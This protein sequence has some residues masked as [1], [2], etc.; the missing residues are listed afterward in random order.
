MSQRQV[1]A[2][3]VG[4]EW[5]TRKSVTKV[6]KKKKKKREKL[7]LWFLYSVF[8]LRRLVLAFTV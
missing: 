8:K 3:Y 5:L 6:K 4:R 1:S 2:L 7:F